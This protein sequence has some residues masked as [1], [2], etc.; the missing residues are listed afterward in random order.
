MRRSSLWGIAATAIVLVFFAIDTV[1]N[2]PETFVAIVAIAVP[3]GRSRPRLEA[4]AWPAARGAVRPLR[5]T[6]A[7]RLAIS[8][9]LWS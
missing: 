6:V 2:S 1:R 5:H 8:M 7:F 4:G 3:R 9:S